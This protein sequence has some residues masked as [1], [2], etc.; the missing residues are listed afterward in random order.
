MEAG[1]T[2][3]VFE[4]SYSPW[5]GRK[6]PAPPPS[7]YD[8][9]DIILISHAHRDHLHPRSIAR[10]SSGTV[11]LCPEPSAMHVDD[12][13]HEVRVMSPGDEY[14][15]PGGNI[16]AVPAHHPGGRNSFRAGHDGDALGYV[17]RTSSRTIYYSGDTEH[18]PGLYDIGRK[19]RPDI[20]ILNINTHLNSYDAVLAI[21]ALGAPTVIPS[22]FGASGGTNARRS[23][24]WRAELGRLIGEVV[25]P[26]G[27]GESLPLPGIRSHQVRKRPVSR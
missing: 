26:L 20:A 5:H 14:E 23:P 4:D 22:H 12:L 25:V 27:V 6:I 21:G 18:F 19:Y 2:D 15:F 16:V 3:P 17:I 8:Q 1:L 10:F 9:T 7:A 24:G 11:I 13:G